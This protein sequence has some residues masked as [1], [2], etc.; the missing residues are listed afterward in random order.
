MT[1]AR[2][3]GIHTAKYNMLIL[4]THWHENKYCPLEDKTNWTEFNI[5]YNITCARILRGMSKED[6]SRL[7]RHKP[8]AVQLTFD[9]M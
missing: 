9:G 8:V 1:P 3:Q 2:L 6:I 5:G 4:K 7:S